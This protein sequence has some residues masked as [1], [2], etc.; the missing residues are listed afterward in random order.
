M[1]DVRVEARGRDV[2]LCWTPPR[3]AVEVRV[4]RK[5]G[6]RPNNPQD[7]ERVDSTLEQAHDRGLNPDRVYHYGIFAVY[8]TPDGRAVAS[9]GSFVSAQPHTPVHTPGAPTVIAEPDGRVLIRW[10]E[11]SRGLL[12]L[13][14]TTSPPPHPP[15]TRLTPA[16]VSALTGDWVEVNG[17]DH[18]FDTPP[19]VGVCYYSPMTVWGGMTLV[20]HPATYSNLTDP[21]DLR[22]ARAEGNQVHLR[23]R[24]SPHGSQSLVVAKAVTPPIGPDDPDALV[25]TVHESDYA[26]HGRY[27]L[28]LPTDVAGPWHVAVYASMTIDGRPVASPGRESS[29]RTVVLGAG[30]EVTVSY[31]FRRGRLTGRKPAIVFQTEPPGAS[32]PATVLVAH[33]RTVPLAIED[34]ETVAS[35]PSTRDGAIFPLPADVD[36]KRCRVRLF[37]GENSSLLRLRHPEADA[38]RV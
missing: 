26:H 30:A 18:T 31:T 33:P 10:V 15:G 36:L 6:G 5:R 38:S 35:F 24:W 21:T 9:L 27:T 19:A 28:S 37:A 12:K 8:R 25:E 29:A 17:Q 4:V 11:P 14:R 16:Q 22:A 23:W 3:G 13:L 1:S 20:G 34:G 32:I 7:G 2:E